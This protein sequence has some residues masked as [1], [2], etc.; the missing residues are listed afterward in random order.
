MR[1]FWTQLYSEQQS[2]T[3]M[4]RNIMCIGGTSAEV[5]VRPFPWV[6]F[7]CLDNFPTL[8]RL[9]IFIIAI[10][11]L[12]LFNWK[13]NLRT[14]ILCVYVKCFLLEQST[15]GPITNMNAW[16]KLGLYH[17]A[18]CFDATKNIKTKIQHYNLLLLLTVDAF[19]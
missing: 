5:L 16:C 15:C 7:S 3:F 13:Y 17:F 12:I 8:W 10:Q 14:L 11:L 19:M 6:R 18:H 4:W 1:S 9:V 2:Y